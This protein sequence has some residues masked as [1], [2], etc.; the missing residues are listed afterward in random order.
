MAKA[1]ETPRQKMISLMYLIFIALLA[2]NVSREVLDAFI[3]VNERVILNNDNSA[4]KLQTAY[5]SFERDFNFNP[6]KVGPYWEKAQLVHQLSDEMLEY[7]KKLK[8]EVIANTENISFSAAKT[9]QMSELKSK[10]NFTEPTSYFIGNSEDG[11]KGKAGELKIKINE[12]RKKMTEL[13]EPVSGH[14]IRLGLK[15]DG[16]YYNADKEAQNWEMHNFY[17]TILLADIVILNN[18]VSEVY[19]AEIDVLKSLHEAIGAEDFH[20]DNGNIRILAKSSYVFIGE[21]YEAEIVV[22][23]YDTTQNP[24]AYFLQGA[25]SLPVSQIPKADKLNCSNGKIN[26]SLPAVTEG[27][28]KYAGLV[29]VKNNAGVITD[30]HFSDEYI[31]ARPS[32]TVSANKMNVLY[33]GAQNNISISVPGIPKSDLFPV[34]ST[35]TLKPDLVNG[36]WLAE[37]LPGYRQ[38]SISVKA[39]ILG[40]YKE[41]GVQVFRVKKLPDPVASIANKSKGFINKEILIA[42]GSIIPKMPDDFEYDLTFKVVSF[43]VTIQ[44]GFNV[45]H[46]KSTNAKL[47]DEMI[48]NIQT[49]NRGQN[50]V[51]E[52]IVAVG[53]DG[54]ER[55]LSPIVLSVN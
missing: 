12:Y 39:K 6:T 2:L 38:V 7:L 48:K 15:T 17:N 5:I 35:G 33:I 34:I 42:A 22:A 31:V 54:D 50:I 21:N 4:K 55:S 27:V 52:D 1:N 11:S 41:M 49:M 37:V 25:D 20:Y 43:M 10:D 24:E 23:A 9:V 8:Y 13:V 29:R 26:L 40:K 46:F 36:D 14:K 51:F 53:P 32:L 19:N 30:Y 3:I 16:T 47:T 45:Y 28:H 18:L 44:R